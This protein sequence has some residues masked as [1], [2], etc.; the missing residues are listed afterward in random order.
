MNIFAVDFLR[1]YKILQQTTSAIGSFRAG[2]S[3]MVLLSHSAQC[4]GSQSTYWHYKNFYYYYYYL[5]LLRVLSA[6]IES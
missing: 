1:A 4:F 2:C 3:C 5:L 6:F